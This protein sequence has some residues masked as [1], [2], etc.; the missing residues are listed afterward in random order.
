MSFFQHVSALYSAY[1][2]RRPL[3]TQ[4]ATA[5]TLY[6]A[7]DVVAQNLAPEDKK[8][9]WHRTLTMTVIGGCAL[10]PTMAIWY[11]YLQRR[12]H[13]SSKLAS[14]IVQV[15]T[16]QLVFAPIS[17]VGLFTLVQLA[18]ATSDNVT[19]RLELARHQVE[20]TFTD[21][22]IQN[23]KLWPG[24]QMV[25]F[26]FVPLQYR[27]LVSNTVAIFWSAYVSMNA[28]KSTEKEPLKTASTN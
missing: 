20:S 2:S 7:G 25:N 10:G 1:L 5:A 21:V 9:D 23:Y 19:E 3:F 24:V 16:D 8:Y 27:L 6:T 13:L 26:F 17:I 11:R 12:V 14:T 28:N 4:S 18:K 22:L 15:A